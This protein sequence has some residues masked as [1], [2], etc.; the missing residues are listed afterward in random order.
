MSSE[1]IGYRAPPIVEALVELRFRGSRPW[2]DGLQQ[3]IVGRLRG[4]YPGQI[5]T[6]GQLRL[7]AR[8]EGAAVL[9][10]GQLELD[11]LFLSDEGGK[12]MVGLG[13]HRL[14]V[15]VLAPYPG[16]ADFQVRIASALAAF[17]DTSAPEGV[18]FISVRYIDRVALPDSITTFHDYL[19]ILPPRPEHAPSG[20]QAF[21]VVTQAHD[22]ELDY[23]AVL[24]VAS[25][26]PDDGKPVVLYDLNVVRACDTIP[27]S[28]EQTLAHIEFLH[29]Q[30]KL[31][32]EDSITERTR[33]L[34]R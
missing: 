15:H 16:W 31:I 2:N 25:A 30:Q 34:F 24:T 18:E 32:F 1:T 14:S 20:L 5:Q 7:A 13:H 4:S 28:R 21:H 12:A 33:E 6:A 10:H 3:E 8:V 17:W 9:T 11:V 29:K 19:P 27:A 22:A 23:A 26:P